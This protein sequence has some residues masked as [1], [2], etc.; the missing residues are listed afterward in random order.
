MA[1]IRIKK[2]NEEKVLCP[3]CSEEI[4][5]IIEK[6][7]KTGAFNITSKSIYACS[8]CRKVIPVAHSTYAFYVVV[9]HLLSSYF[10]FVLI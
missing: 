3:H 1:E 9:V 2:D 4:T 10:L 5:E 7:A 8:K 6:T